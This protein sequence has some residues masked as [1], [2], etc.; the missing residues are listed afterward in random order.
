[1]E[2]KTIAGLIAV[3]AVVAVTMYM[4]CVGASLAAPASEPTLA[5]GYEWYHDDEFSYKIGYPK[6]CDKDILTVLEGQ[7]AG[8]FF[9]STSSTCS[10]GV[11]VFSD[12]TQARWWESWQGGLE[13]YKERGMVTEYGK[14]T[15][16]DREGYEVVFKPLPTVKSRWIEFTVDD[17]YYVISVS[18]QEEEYDKCAK[19]FETAINSF[20]IEYPAPV[21]ATPTPASTSTPTP[22]PTPSPTEASTPT[23][24][25][26][27]EKGALGFKAI[28]A[29]VGLFVVAY[30]LRKRE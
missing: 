6:N 20:V 7:E 26:T 12:P 21:T 4:G 18:A 24:T 29:I 22:T 28:Y 15:I 17:L 9:T 2:N 23:S 14:I 1:M 11:T 3:I 16:N 5:S 27:P 30:L 25:T 13:D 8:I 10:I 19:T